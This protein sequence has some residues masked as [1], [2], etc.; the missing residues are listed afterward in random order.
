M[1]TMGEMSPNIP[2]TKSMV[3]S[4]V[5]QHIKKSSYC[6]YK[7]GLND[8]DIEDFKNVKEKI[9][10]IDDSEIIR[11]SVIKLFSQLKKF[12]EKYEIIQGSDGIDTLYMIKNDQ[13]N[14]NKIVM[15]ISD[16]NMEF[17]QGSDSFKIL[18]E[19]EKQKK[20]C[21]RI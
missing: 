12:D 8:N 3:I 16:E 6:S 13:M 2:Q 1:N 5:S 20:I 21:K 17:M 4:K 19:F 15:I 10:I 7:S 11:K 18:T 14:G 9:L